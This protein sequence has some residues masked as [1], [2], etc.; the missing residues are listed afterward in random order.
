[1][2]NFIAICKFSVRLKNLN[3]R[4]FVIKIYAAKFEFL[5]FMTSIVI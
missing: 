5:K 3:L 1:M 4:F 2:H